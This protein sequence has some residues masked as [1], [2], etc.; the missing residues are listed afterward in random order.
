MNIHGKDRAR[1][2]QPAVPSVSTSKPNNEYVSPAGLQQRFR[3]WCCVGDR[4]MVAAFV[5]ETHHLF[6]ATLAGIRCLPESIG[7]IL[8]I[9]PDLATPEQR[10]RQSS[11]VWPLFLSF[12]FFSS[13]SFHLSSSSPLSFSPTSVLT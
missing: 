13:S 2:K 7:K 12:P 9:F 3:R 1:I 6:A 4:E 11:P 5:A 10:H 8:F